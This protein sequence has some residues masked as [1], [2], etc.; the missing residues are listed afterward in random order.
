MI[1]CIITNGMNMIIKLLRWRR[2]ILKRE[3]LNLA[4]ISDLGYIPNVIYIMLT[5]I[6]FKY[7]QIFY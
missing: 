4:Y 6:Y 2:T 7:I 3:M 1:D 5:I